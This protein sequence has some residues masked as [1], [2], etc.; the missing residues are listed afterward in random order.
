MAQRGLDLLGSEPD[1]SWTPAQVLAYQQ[2][3]LKEA[4]KERNFE[5][6]RQDTGKARNAVVITLCLAAASIPWAVGG[7]FVYKYLKRKK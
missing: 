6:K 1:S 2:A 4:E 5:Q 3:M 7:Y